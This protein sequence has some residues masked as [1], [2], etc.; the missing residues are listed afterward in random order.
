MA[1]NLFNFVKTDTGLH[2]GP[3]SVAQLVIGD[4]MEDA[5]VIITVEHEDPGS[6]KW[7]AQKSLS[8]KQLHVGRGKF[9]R[10]MK[11]VH[12]VLQILETG[13]GLLQYDA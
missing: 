12:I 1:C 9:K 10:A 11:P 13:I 8:G 3:E 5:E 6:K 2:N 4:R 7:V